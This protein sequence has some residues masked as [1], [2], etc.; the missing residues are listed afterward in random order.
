MFLRRAFA[1]F[2]PLEKQEIAEN[3]GEVWGVDPR[4]A[5]EALTAALTEGEQKVLDELSDFDFDDI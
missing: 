4:Q 1:D 3:L 2:A 5:A